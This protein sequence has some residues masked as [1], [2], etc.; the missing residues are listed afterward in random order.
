MKNYVDK[1]KLQ[2]YSAKLNAKLKTIFATKAEIG[3]P[4]VASTV[5]EMTDESRVYVYTGSE[6]GYTAGN[7][8]YYDGSAWISGGVYNSTAFETDAT[9]AIPGAAADAKAVGDA[10]NASASAVSAN[11]AP[12]YSS[13]A[14]YAVGD[15]VIYDNDLYRCTVAISTAEAWTAVHWTAVKLGPD[16]N[17]LK[18]TIDS[19]LEIN[20]DTVLT[21]NDADYNLQVNTN[22]TDPVD[23]PNGTRIRVIFVLPPYAEISAQCSYGKGLAI[24]EFSNLGKAVNSATSDARQSAPSSGYS[25]AALTMTTTNTSDECYV[26]FS[27]SKTDGTAFTAEE[28]AEAFA[29]LNITIRIPGEHR[30]ERLDEIESDI[31]ELDN[32]LAFVSETTDNRFGELITAVDSGEVPIFVTWE[33]GSISSTTGIDTSDGDKTRAR[34]VEK[35]STKDCRIINLHT[36][37]TYGI[38]L[39]FYNSSDEFVYRATG[40]TNVNINVDDTYPYFRVAVLNAV[41]TSAVLNMDSVR[42]DITFVRKNVYLQ[43]LSKNTFFQRQLAKMLVQKGYNSAYDYAYSTTRVSIPTPI[44]A[45]RAFTIT[46]KAD[47]QVDIYYWSDYTL[48]ESTYISHTGFVSAPQMIPSDSLVT[49]TFRKS[50]NSEVSVSDA[51]N[52]FDVDSIGNSFI[53]NYYDGTNIICAAHRGYSKGAPENTLPAYVFARRYGFNA[54]ETDIQKTYDGRF[55]MLHDTTVDRTSNGSGNVSDFTLEELKSLDFGSWY[56]ASWAGTKI[57]TLEETLALCRDIGLSILLEI[58]DDGDFT[59]SDIEKIVNI[60]KSYNMADRVIY[61]TLSVTYLTYVKTYAPNS[62][63]SRVCP[64]EPN[65]TFIGQMS[66]LLSDTNSVGVSPSYS[67]LTSEAVELCKD[68]G[69][70]MTVRINDIATLSTVDDYVSM[71]SSDTMPVQKEKYRLKLFG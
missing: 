24:G 13:S 67:D 46:M 55:V 63:I 34:I 19:I 27:L 35:L 50:D 60:V 21:K 61:I 22:T 56:N 70:F 7:W 45:D 33:N 41:D 26:S 48:S 65:E 4:L 59:E 32:D 52:C 5:A 30:S 20:S 8:Y 3:S 6:S 44:R 64:I 18:S 14:T 38:Y 11:F 17:E 10:I 16:V 40:V 43:G 47:Y 15:Y 9:L 1:E 53:D 49:I 2:E 51:Q 57:P 39:Y 29:A 36:N 28:R 58:K 66:G 42:A 54:I 71:F 23:N 69:Y 62:V 37:A 31:E 12:T 68:A 25:S